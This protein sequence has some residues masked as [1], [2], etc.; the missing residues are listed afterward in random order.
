MIAIGGTVLLVVLTSV[1]PAVGLWQATT[2]S[3]AKVEAI[4][5]TSTATIS[6][7]LAAGTN[8]VAPLADSQTLFKAEMTYLGEVVYDVTGEQTK[9]IKLENRANNVSVWDLFGTDLHMNIG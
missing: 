5:N 6:V 7:N 2:K 9:V 3:L 1:G 4:G 8:T